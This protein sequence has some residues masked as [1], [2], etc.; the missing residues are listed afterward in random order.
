MYMHIDATTTMAMKKTAAVP[1]TAQ[2][3]PMAMPSM[4]FPLSLKSVR[5]KVMCIGMILLILYAL[6]HCKITK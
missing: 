2:I 3:T 4:A 5:E 1:T 6:Y